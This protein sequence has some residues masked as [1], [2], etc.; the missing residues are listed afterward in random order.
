MLF[1]IKNPASFYQLPRLRGKHL[2]FK[3]MEIQTKKTLHVEL[4]QVE[5]SANENNSCSACVTVQDKLISAIQDVQKLFD[6]IDLEIFFKSTTIKTVG[7]AQKAQI[8]A[9]PT[10]RVGNLDFYPEHLKESSETRKW[11]WNGLTMSEPEIETLIEVVLKGYFEPKRENDKKE[12]SPYIFK[13]LNA[14]ETEQ[15]SCGCS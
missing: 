1:N 3:T 15:S 6:R 13:H 11:I 2:N 5:M 8:I 12:I 7:E 14:E 10:I 4:F 9:S